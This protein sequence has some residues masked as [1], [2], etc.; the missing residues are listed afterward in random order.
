MNSK[1]WAVVEWPLLIDFAKY[2]G[3]D[4]KKAAFF[5]RLIKGMRFGGIP[6]ALCRATHTAYVE[7]NPPRFVDAKTNEGPL[8]YVYE[9]KSMVNRKID[10]EDIVDPRGSVRAK[11]LWL[12]IETG[13]VDPKARCTKSKN[14]PKDVFFKRIQAITCFASSTMF[15]DY[16]CIVCLNASNIEELLQSDVWRE[17]F[18]DF[19]V[20]QEEC[21]KYCPWGRGLKAAL[22]KRGIDSLAKAYFDRIQNDP[23]SARNLTMLLVY[24]Y[25]KMI[26]NSDDADEFAEF[27][28]GK[29]PAFVQKVD[30]S[31]L[32]E[33]R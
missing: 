21:A 12:S 20:A 26:M 25:Y 30:L 18:V 9:E 33:N 4:P 10:I 6:C 29:E 7:E 15:L 22:D 8:D 19:L 3:S 28:R 14:L 17:G 13:R 2:A 5:E 1:I 11:T 24:G 23:L 32:N 31:F 27:V 16:T